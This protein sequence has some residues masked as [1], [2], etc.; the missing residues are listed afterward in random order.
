[1]SNSFVLEAELRKDQGK[2]ASRRLR[3]HEGKVP[4]IIYGAKKD[5]VA[6]SLSAN[7]LAKASAHEAFYSHVLTIKLD[8][9]EESTIIKDMQRHPARGDIM[10]A[11]FLRI[12]KGQALTVNIPIHYVNEE[13]CVGVKMEGGVILHQILEVEISCLPKDLP[14]YIEVDMKDIHLDTILHLSDIKLPKGITI[15]ELQYGEDHDHPIAS[16]HKPKTQVEED[17][18]TTETQDAA[19]DKADEDKAED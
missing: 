12:V 4:G 2:G 7:E 11:D 3:L 16:V 5:A 19:E 6:I 1:M 17:A 9:K 10:H 15:N 13:Q 8:G 18:D 14:E